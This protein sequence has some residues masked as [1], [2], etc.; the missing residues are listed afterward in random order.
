[1][2]VLLLAYVL[3]VVAFEVRLGVNQPENQSTIVIA[4]FDDDGNRSE[5]VVRLVEIDGNAYVAANHWPRAWYHEA[6][7]NP[8][9]EV[10]MDDSFE[11]YTA[12]PLEGAEEA[13]L[14]E[15]YSVGFG[16][17]FRTGFPPRY[18]MRLDPQ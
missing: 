2:C 11:P 10:Q 3:Q 8:Q 7:E 18:F 17:R 5:R 1:M 16:F 14:R 15:N 12:V 13:M 6:L 4:T 9:I